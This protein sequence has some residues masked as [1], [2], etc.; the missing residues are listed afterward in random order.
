MEIASLEIEAVKLIR[1]R[2]YRDPRGYFVETWNRRVFAE[3]GIDVDF[4]Q[5]NCSF[6]ELPGTIR[7]LHYQTPPRAQ[8]K[9]VR[10]VQGSLFDVAVDL[11]RSAPTFGRHVS[12]V[13]SAENGEQLF[14]PI[15]FAHGFCTLE[16]D[17]EVAYK[18][19]DFFSPEHDTGIAWDDEALAIAWPLDGLSPVLSDKDRKLP[20]LS[21][22][23]S[24]F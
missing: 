22:S 23:E 8:A 20:R 13:L 14:V 9:L 6:S 1:P 11:R 7:G 24:V 17:T 5:D 3:C 15:G 4:V 19:S 2:R 21:E 18:T 10:A 12:A 16:P